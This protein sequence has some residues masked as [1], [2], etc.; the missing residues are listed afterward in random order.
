MH[1]PFITES[2]VHST[3]QTT[4]QIAVLYHVHTEYCSSSIMN[5][6]YVRSIPY[7]FT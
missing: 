2:E 7:G 4:L 6:L 1:V 3:R 5:V